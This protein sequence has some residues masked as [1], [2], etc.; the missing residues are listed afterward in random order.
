G[1][2]NFGVKPSYMAGVLL[3]NPSTNLAD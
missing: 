1:D 2:I 3:P